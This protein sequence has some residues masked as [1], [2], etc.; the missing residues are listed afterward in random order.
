MFNP[1][2]NRY[3]FIV[4][5]KLVNMTKREEQKENRKEEKSKRRKRIER[6]TVSIN[7]RATNK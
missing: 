4:K 5:T 2:M 3:I 7:I 1:C 6:H